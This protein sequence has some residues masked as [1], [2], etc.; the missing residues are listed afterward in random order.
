[1]WV[2]G[3]LLVIGEEKRLMK[4]FNKNL[5]LL[6]LNALSLFLIAFL[7]V[8]SNNNIFNGFM[9]IVCYIFFGLGILVFLSFNN[10]I[11]IT[12][13][14]L[15]YHD[16]I[17]KK[18]IKWEEIENIQIFI[19]SINE[20]RGFKKITYIFKDSEYDI[21]PLTINKMVK[22][23]VLAYNQTHLL[24]YNIDKY[25]RINAKVKRA[26]NKN[27]IHLPIVKEKLIEETIKL[28]YLKMKFYTVY[29]Y[30][31]ILFILIP[32]RIYNI[33]FNNDKQLFI[34]VVCYFLVIVL[35]SL[36][37]GLKILLSRGR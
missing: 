3:L 35:F 6:L 23:L 30:L 8:D 15:L 31:T 28:E 34:F 16:I 10:F 12:N 18:F 21:E 26:I 7:K 29:C 22:Y 36:F 20:K 24:P 11:V 27:N 19:P 37:A 4:I 1:M 5:L 9:K 32:S 33:I 13:K 2:F 17:K 14:V 25:R